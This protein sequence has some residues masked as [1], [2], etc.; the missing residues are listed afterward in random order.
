MADNSS[1]AGM[2]ADPKSYMQAQKLQMLTQ[3]LMGNMQQATRAPENWD[4]MRVV[5]KM[6]P[7][8]GL[9]GA[10]S[11]G[12]AGMSYGK[13]MQAQMTNAQAVRAAQAAA[14]GGG[15][16]SFEAAPAAPEEAPDRG[17]LGATSPLSLNAPLGVSGNPLVEAMMAKRAPARQQASSGADPRYLRALNQATYG[18]PD[19]IT[20]AYLSDTGP[21]NEWRNALTMAGGDQNLAMQILRKPTLPSRPG[22]PIQNYKGETVGYTPLATEGVQMDMGPDGRPVASEISGMQPL[23]ADLK[24]KETAAQEANKIGTMPGVGGSTQSGWL[25]DLAGPPPAAR[26]APAAPVAPSVGHARPSQTNQPPQGSSLPFG[27]AGKQ[28]PPDFRDAV[29]MPQIGGRGRTPTLIEKGVADNI[30]KFDEEQTS[31]FNEASAAATKRIAFNN[32]A[33]RVLSGSDTGP[34]SD[35]LNKLRSMALE[36]GIDT[37]WIPGAETIGNTAELKKFLLRN[38]LLNLKPIFGSK[39]AAAEFQILSKEASPSTEMLQSTIRRL[40]ELDNMDAGYAQHQLS[41]YEKYKAGG[42]R[43]PRAFTS[44]YNE[45]YPY[46]AATGSTDTNSAVAPTID[47]SDRAAYDALLPGAVYHIKGNPKP[48]TKGKK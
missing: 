28:P 48:L 24:G 12:L 14:L 47:P 19:E 3:M 32:E 5:P 35:R 20:K 17:F 30:N 33:L 15:G 21:T 46:S 26:G 8:A 10:L 27:A 23:I 38:P 7:L 22:M 43:D 36:A 40:V 4:S 44:W 25:G 16:G 31:K 39:P 42:A 6:S 45:H 13:A 9:A 29:P 2:L 37:K 11:G 18:V 34:L 41:T 1:M